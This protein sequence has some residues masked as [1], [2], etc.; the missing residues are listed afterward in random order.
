MGAC[1]DSTASAPELSL[2]PT[3][4]ELDYQLG[5]HYRPPPG[6]TVVVRDRGAPPADA[7]SICY[8]NGFQTQPDDADWWLTEHPDLVLR[9]GSGDP[10]IDPEWP[11]EM[12]LDITTTAKRGEVAGIVGTWIDGC[13][14][15]GFDAVEID[16]LDSYTRSGGRIDQGTAVSAIGLLADRAHAAGLPVGQKNATELLDRRADTRLDFAVAEECTRYDECGDYVAT[17]GDRVYLVEYNREHFDAACAAYPRLAVVQRD[18]GLEPAGA[19]GYIR[20]AC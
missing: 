5:G 12:L 18:L 4:G 10:V 15:D 17:Y 2:P 9:T 1:G 3:H 20:R 6:V 11:D 8:V 16:N 19:A 7:Y 13:A 14:A